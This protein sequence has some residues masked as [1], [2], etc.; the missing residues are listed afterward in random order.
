MHWRDIWAY[1]QPWWVRL[2]IFVT[3]VLG[4][5]GLVKMYWSIM[6][7]T[8]DEK[9]RDY[10]IASVGPEY[11]PIHGNFVRDPM[12]RSLSEIPERSCGLG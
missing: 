9:I 1:A 11:R 6:E 10:L 4:V 8:A 2:T 5:W 12:P 7:R 3:A